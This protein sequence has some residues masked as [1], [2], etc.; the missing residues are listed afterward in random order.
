MIN[1]AS[2]NLFAA[3]IF[4]LSFCPKGNAAQDNEPMR[5][6]IDGTQSNQPFQIRHDMNDGDVLYF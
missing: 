6:L 3:I 1:K 5:Y 2:P 4:T